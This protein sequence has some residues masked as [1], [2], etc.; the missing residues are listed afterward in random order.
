MLWARTAAELDAIRLGVFQ[1][2][3][4]AL[5]ERLADPEARAVGASGGSRE[6]LP[7]A[8]IADLDETLLDNS[9]FEAERILQPGGRQ[10]SWREWVERAEAEALPGA[11]EFLRRA[12]VLG[13]TVFY[14]TNRDVTEEPATRRNLQ[15]LGFPLSSSADTVLSRGEKEGWGSDKESR[16]QAITREYRVLLV[17]GDDLNDFVSARHLGIR[18]RRELIRKTQSHWGRDWFMLPNPLYGSWKRA[19]AG[20]Q[21]RML[22]EAEKRELLRQ[23]WNF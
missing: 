6:P 8:V 16:R 12:D 11:L 5:E 2:A 14:V 10:P 17:L 13:V 21:D 23:N 7:P 3:T 19:L 20:G 18:E 15:R 22:S 9:R 1:A 4:R